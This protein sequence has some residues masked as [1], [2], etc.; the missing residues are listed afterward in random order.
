MAESIKFQLDVSK[1]IELLSE[2]IYDSPFAM[3]RENI[4]NAYDAILLRTFRAPKTFDP[5]ISVIVTRDA[6][7]VEDNGVGMTFNEVEN[8]F[9]RA[10][11]SGKNTAEARSAGVV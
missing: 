11:A 9:W 1:V 5:I 7:T 8:N 6:I 4:Q 2:R 10:G 3:L